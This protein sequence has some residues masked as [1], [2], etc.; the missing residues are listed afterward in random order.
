MRSQ[1]L[2]SDSFGTEKALTNADPVLHDFRR[3][4]RDLHDARLVGKL[5]V[6]IGWAGKS[7]PWLDAKKSGAARLRP[8]P[9]LSKSVP[10]NR[11]RRA[12]VGRVKDRPAGKAIE[13][14]CVII[15]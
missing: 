3:A 10:R 6:E 15:E 9:K 5:A 13:D 1:G 8:G 11:Q 4:R 7:A 12:F 14:D 2:R